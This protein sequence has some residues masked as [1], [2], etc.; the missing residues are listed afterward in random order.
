MVLAE[1]GTHSLTNAERKEGV[2]DPVPQ[3][4]RRLLDE[5]SDLIDS[6]TTKTV[7]DQILNAAFS[8]L[9]DVKLAGNA[10]KPK[11]MALPPTQPSDDESVV[12]EQ[13]QTQAEVDNAK[14]TKFASVLAVLARQAYLIG[15]GEPNEYLQVCAT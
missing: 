10:F 8:F 15:N 2:V 9:L 13:S 7:M 3:S 12:V 5:T 14:T 1:S 4:L 6:P 11:A